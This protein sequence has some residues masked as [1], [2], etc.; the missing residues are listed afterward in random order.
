MPTTVTGSGPFDA[1]G[2]DKCNDS[3]RDVSADHHR[4]ERELD[5]NGE[6][7]HDGSGGA[8]A[9]Q[10]QFDGDAEYAD[11]GGGEC[12]DVDG[13]HCGAERIHWGGDAERER[14]AGGSDSEFRAGDGDRGPKVDADGDE[15]F[16]DS[17]RNV[18]TDHHGHERNSDPDRECDSGGDERQPRLVSS[19]WARARR[20]R[21]RKWPGL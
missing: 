16:H 7:E 21:V 1:D 9:A 12:D 13:Q 2:D 10:L 18:S 17:A 6:C 19:L 3:A 4:H 20:W 5:A 14:T 8:A 11:G 15:Q